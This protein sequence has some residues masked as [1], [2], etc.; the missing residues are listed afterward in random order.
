MVIFF[1][2]V[3][4]LTERNKIEVSIGAASL[5]VEDLRQVTAPLKHSLRICNVQGCFQNIQGAWL[6]L[7]ALLRLNEVQTL[8][9]KRK[10]KK[11]KTKTALVKEIG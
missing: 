2:S 5:L 10:Q 6:L 1:S 9:S 11:D 3:K 4:H 8:H 7:E